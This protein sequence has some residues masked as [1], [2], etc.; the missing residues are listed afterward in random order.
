MQGKIMP[1][2]NH[3]DYCHHFLDLF[4]HIRSNYANPKN[5]NYYA[6]GEWHALS[7]VEMLTEI[8][9]MTYGLVSLGLQ[10][11]QIGWQAGQKVG[12][13]AHPSPR[14]T[15]IN[16]SIILA[17]GI[18]VPLFPNLSKENFLHEVTET[19]MKIIFVE[20]RELLPICDL[21]STLCSLIIEI[22][23]QL[24]STLQEKELHREIISY[25]ALLAK[26]KAYE[27]HHPSLFDELEKTKREEDVAAI[28]YTSATT[29]VPKGVQLTHKNL[30]HQL[31]FAPL[32]IEK[33]ATRYLSLLPLAH[34]FGHALNLI[35]L[36]RGASIYYS[37]DIKNLGAICREIHPTITVV[38]PR[39]LEK[40]YAKMQ[41]AVQAAGFMKRHLAQWA[42]ELA[43]QEESSLVKYLAHPVVDAIVYAQLRDSM[44]GAIQAVV[45]GGASLD[46]HLNHFFREIGVPIYEGWG[47]TEACPITVNTIENNKIGTVGLP[48]KDYELKIG[49]DDEICV[50]GVNVMQGYYQHPEWTNKVI[51]EAGWFHTGDK[52]KIDV[53]GFLTIQG[54]LKELYKTSTGEW[55]APVPIE[56]AICQAPLIDMAMVIAEGRKYV[57]C[58]LFPDHDVLKSL[59]AAQHLGDLSDREFLDAPFVKGEMVNLFHSLN[60]HLNHWEQVHAYRFILEIPSIEGGE[61]TP[62]LKLRREEIMKKYRDLVENL[63]SEENTI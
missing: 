52:G 20:K 13:I 48:L 60:Q 27:I 56:Q 34:I 41:T 55:V 25:E 54:R 22:N 33:E 4:K 35:M 11:L 51:D 43:N 9:W 37:N 36:Y 23:P 12:L 44:G 30:L 7:T 39:I 2:E 49:L 47:M 26:G 57:S 32:L 38:V 46:P 59:K 1:L 61:I 53:E 40:I 3:L 50:K 19:D 18:I 24:N 31:P 8:K 29:G 16:F 45:S 17:R 62:S 14:W 63:Y 28:I 58:L 6:N 15:I 5:L 21:A 10:G 42:F